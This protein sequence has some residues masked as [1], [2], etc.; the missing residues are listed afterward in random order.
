MTDNQSLIVCHYSHSYICEEFFLHRWCGIHVGTVI[1]RNI[2]RVRK[3]AAS[4]LTPICTL[5][6]TYKCQVCFNL[7]DDGFALMPEKNHVWKQ[8]SPRRNYKKW[9]YVTWQI[10]NNYCH[11]RVATI[12]CILTQKG[13]CDPL[14]LGSILQLKCLLNNLGIVLLGSLSYEWFSS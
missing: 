2:A 11:I 6:E 1:S 10:V 4:V 9:Q 14:F 13:D 12:S 5:N 3:S 7:I 8:W